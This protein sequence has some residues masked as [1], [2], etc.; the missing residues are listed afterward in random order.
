ME[1]V[2]VLGGGAFGTVLANLMTLNGANVLMW[3]RNPEVADAINLQHENHS[4][5]PGYRLSQDLKATSDLKLALADA[6]VVFS[7]I[8][9]SSFRSV[10]SDMRT[11]LGRSMLISTTKGIEFGSFKTMGQ[12]LKELYPSHAVGVVSGPNLAKEIVAGQIT[13]T[14]VASEESALVSRVQAL[15]CSKRFRVYSSTDMLGVELGGALKNIYAIASGLSHALGMGENS[16]SL[17]ITRSLSEMTRFAVAF[18]ARA[19]TF[20]GLAGAGDL[21]ATCSSPL[22]RNFQ[23]G[24]ALGQGRT[25]QDAM[26]SVSGVAEGV[27]TLRAVKEVADR[28]GIRMPLVTGLHDIVFGSREVMPVVYELMMN[29]PTTDVDVS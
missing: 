28:K 12:I 22:S 17:L 6:D 3:V 5:L 11:L 15:L 8:P 29:E 25:V 14:V 19:E 23:L 1:R 24:L 4:R 20:A 16:R 26:G 21:I 9:S 13:G 27:N 2:A 7:A 18:G 10:M